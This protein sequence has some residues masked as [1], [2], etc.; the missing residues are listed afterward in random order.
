MI[1]QV[2]GEY[3]QASAIMSNPN[4]DPH[5]FEASIAVAREVGN[6]Q[7]IS[8]QRTGSAGRTS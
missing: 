7:L 2:G 1:S 6:A 5:S 3:V 4:T 8:V